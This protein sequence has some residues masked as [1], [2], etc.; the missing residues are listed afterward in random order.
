MNSSLQLQRLLERLEVGVGLRRPRLRSVAD[1]DEAAHA[2]GLRVGE[3]GRVA[4][5]SERQRLVVVEDH[6]VAIG[7]ERGV[8]RVL[9]EIDR[10]QRAERAGRFVDR[11]RTVRLLAQR[12]QV[13]VGAEVAAAQLRG[14]PPDALRPPVVG[15][16]DR[17]ACRRSPRR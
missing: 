14:Q 17:R 15:A 8:G 6:L 12:Q 11:R 7:V 1:V 16:L 3:G 10:Q 2:V 5:A 4:P 9:V 13:D